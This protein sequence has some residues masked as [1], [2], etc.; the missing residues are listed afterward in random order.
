M[1]PASFG[2]PG[3]SPAIV[4]RRRLDGLVVA[5]A[6]HHQPG[7]DRA[8]L[9]GMH[10][11]R[12]RR[13]R[14]RAREIGVVEHQERRLAAQFEEH[15]LRAWPRRRPSPRGPV[16]VDPVNDTM[17]T[18]GSFDSS[19]PTPWSLEVTMLT[20]PAGM[21]VCSRISSP[22]TAALHGVSGAGLS[23]T[24]VARRQRGPD[25]GEVDLV[26]EVPRRD[27]ADDADR[28]PGRWCGGS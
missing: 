4:R 26:R 10:R 23:T 17:S 22:S 20:T 24:R 11:R 2:S 7:G 13:H 1:V 27:R 9:A 28:P 25:L 5:G 14:A 21:S 8:A 19:A 3:F 16:F 12:E 6:R 18:R 15:L